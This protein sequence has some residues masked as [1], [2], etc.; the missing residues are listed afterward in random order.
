MFQQWDLLRLH[1]RALTQMQCKLS[2]DSG[3]GGRAQ[4]CLSCYDM[5]V[6]FH[7]FLLLP[8]YT[9]ANIVNELRVCGVFL[10]Y[11][12]ECADLISPPY[13][14]SGA[15]WL[16]KT[17]RFGAADSTNAAHEPFPV[18][19]VNL[20]LFDII[21]PCPPLGLPEL[22]LALLRWCWWALNWASELFL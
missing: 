6:E 2:A 19:L 15:V 7:L 16:A 9:V 8:S 18:C 14:Q 11:T 20:T 5:T 13:K 4:P 10:I 21:R 12:F 3:L 17:R 1:K 22:F